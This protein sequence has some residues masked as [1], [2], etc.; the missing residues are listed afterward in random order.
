M[1]VRVV[2]CM[3]NWAVRVGILAHN[4]I[5][6]IRGLPTGRAY[7]KKPR[8]AM[9]E[10]E[11]ERFVAAAFQIDQEA[12]SRAIAEKTIE[13]GTRGPGY[14]ARERVRHIPQA[15][16]WLSLLETGARFGELTSTCWGDLSESKAALTLRAATTKS[17][18]ERVLPLRRE[19]LDVLRDL[20]VAQHERL[21]RIPGSAERIF[22]SPSGTAWTHN[23]SYVIKRFRAVLELAGIPLVDARGEKLDVHALRVT[24]ATRMARNGV[25]LV[26]AQKLLGHSDPKLTAQVYTQLDAEDLRSGVESL[27]PLKMARG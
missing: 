5:A 3:L 7:E 22:L 16:L 19:L 14:A 6:G 12:A 10:E 13:G 26:V 4:P 8:R 24:S 25:P 1:E 20:R 17:R 9:S 15:P 23:H 18:K 2:G 27:P 11:V 21:G